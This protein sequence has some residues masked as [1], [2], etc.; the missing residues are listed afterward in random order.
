VPAEAG[1]LVARVVRRVRRLEVGGHAVGV[2][3]AEVLGQQR[4]AEAAPA[5]VTGDAEQAQVGV[6]LV[7][8]HCPERLEQREYVAGARPDELAQQGLDPFLVLPGELVGAGRVPHGSG[9]EVAG[10]PRRPVAQAA[11]D[12][13]APPRVEAL[14]A[15]EGP[16]APDRVGR[17]RLG[18]ELRQPVEITAL[19]EPDVHEDAA[20]SA[21]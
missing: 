3:G 21:R 13:E 12:E 16:A 9:L 11:R 5:R 6:R 10:D 14:A 7:R 1:A 2:E 15:G 18:E 19:G 20:T 4:H 8:P 17:E